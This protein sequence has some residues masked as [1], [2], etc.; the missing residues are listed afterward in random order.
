MQVDI[1]PLEITP[2]DPAQIPEPREPRQSGP[3]DISKRVEPC[4]REASYAN[5]R[6]ERHRNQPAVCAEE[7]AAAAAAGVGLCVHHLDL[8]VLWDS[9][10][11]GNGI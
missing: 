4:S 10:R 6:D 3:G 8:F 7:A 5:G 1:N 11:N 9:I 2:Q